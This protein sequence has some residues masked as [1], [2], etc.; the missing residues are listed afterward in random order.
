MN[1]TTLVSIIVMGYLLFVY[2][3]LYGPKDDIIYLWPILV[4]LLVVAAVCVQIYQVGSWIY[5]RLQPWI[6]R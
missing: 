2:D 4:M 1:W 3:E 5:R 6:F